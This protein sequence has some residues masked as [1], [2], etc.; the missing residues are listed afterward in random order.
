MFL[1]TNSLSIVYT[2]FLRIYLSFLSYRGLSLA[3]TIVGLYLYSV[4]T[5]PMFLSTNSLS[6]VYTFF[7]YLCWFVLYLILQAFTNHNVKERE[8]F[9]SV[10]FCINE[11]ITSH[12][13]VVCNNEKIWPFLIPISCLQVFMVSFFSGVSNFSGYPILFTFWRWTVKILNAML[14][15]H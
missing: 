13:D 15:T 7:L 12:E 14:L 11:E 1:S 2:F 10:Y 6:I 3:N 9:I 5:N 4:F 8:G